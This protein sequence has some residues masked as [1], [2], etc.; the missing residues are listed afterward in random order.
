M[1]DFLSIN[2]AI[3]FNTAHVATHIFISLVG[4]DQFTSETIFFFHL[5]LARIGGAE[6]NIDLKKKAKRAKQRQRM[7]RQPY[8]VASSV[9]VT[10]CVLTRPNKLII[11]VNINRSTCGE[12]TTETTNTLTNTTRCT[13]T[14]VCA[15]AYGRDRRYSVSRLGVWVCYYYLIRFGSLVSS[16]CNHTESVSFR[17]LM[18][19]HCVFLFCCC[20]RAHFTHSFSNRP[21]FN[22]VTFSS[23]SYS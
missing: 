2:A 16:L 14:C 7:S 12:N 23:S 20:R 6:V 1:N 17:L 13:Y 10:H 5:F 8:N 21:T 15:S 4:D 9:V 18:S 11:Q 3:R 22:N 19:E